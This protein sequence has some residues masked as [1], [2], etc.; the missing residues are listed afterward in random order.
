M[1]KLT[2]PSAAPRERGYVLLVVILAMLA[3]VALVV[4]AIRF[5]GTNRDGAAAKVRADRLNSCGQAAKRALLSKLSLTN[6]PDPS[7][8]VQNVGLDET[9]PDSVSAAARSRVMTAHFDEDEASVTLF[10]LDAGAMGASR[11]QIRDVAN[12]PAQSLTL[13]GQ[14]YAVVA[15][16]R[17][18]SG[19]ETETEFVIR[20]GGY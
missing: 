15:K 14:Y 17:D 10:K 16:C 12:T 2:V 6:L 18:P 1:R 20:L 4:G 8:L 7:G 5:T 13:G 9:L 19:V 3:A 11:G